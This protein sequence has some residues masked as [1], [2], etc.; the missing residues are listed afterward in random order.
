M[1]I[2]DLSTEIFPGMPRPRSSPPVKRNYILEPSESQEQEL[3]FTN[4][5][6]QYTIT[7]HVATHLDAPS[8]FSLHGKNIDAYPP[9]YFF[10]VPTLMLMIERDE[11]GIITA[12]DIMEAEKKYGEIREGDLVIINTGF[13]RYYREEKY[14]RTPYLTS[15]TAEY[16]AGRKIKMLGTDSFT[17]DDARKKE[18]PAHVILLK[19]HGILIIECIMNLGEVPCPRFYSICLPLKL[20]D[21]SGAFTRMIGIVKERGNEKYE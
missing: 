7:T 4:K 2:I 1:K 9:E 10:M 16:L 12:E 11:Y 5:M 18:K 13:Y 14:N 6:E 3:G 8:H 15:D 19:N 21:A 17:V 20:R